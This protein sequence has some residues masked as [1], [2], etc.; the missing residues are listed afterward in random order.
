[1][2]RKPVQTAYPGMSD[3]QRCYLSQWQQERRELETA[4]AAV[5]RLT[6]ELAEANAKVQAL[7]TTVRLNVIASVKT[8]QLSPGVTLKEYELT[9]E[10]KE[11]LRCNLDRL[12]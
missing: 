8:I 6:T 4:E 3:I 9:E 2:K 5:R 1:V 10:G 12:P 11:L 7:T